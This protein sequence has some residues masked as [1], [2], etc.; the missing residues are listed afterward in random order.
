MIGYPTPQLRKRA[1]LV[2]VLGLALGMAG[3]SSASSGGGDSETG[4]ILWGEATEAAET[5]TDAAAE[6][7]PEAVAETATETAAEA[8]VDPTPFEYPCEPGAREACVTACVSAGQR[9]C[10]KEW[11]PCLPPGEF[12][13]N[14]TDDDCDGQVNEE[15]PLNPECQE[16]PV[17]ECPTAVIS[18]AEGTTVGVGT[19]LHLDG[20]ASTSPNGAVTA[21]AWGV[22]APVG[23]QAAFAPSASIVAPTFQ[24]DLAGQFLFTLEVTDDQGVKGCTPAQVAVTVKPVPP[25]DPEVGCADGQREGFVDLQAYTHIAGC[26]GAWDQPGVSPDSVQPTCG[27]QGGD[28]GQHAD[29]VGCSSVDLCATGWHLC[30]EWQEVAQKSPT[31]C[32]GATPANAPPKSLFFAMR[33]SSPNNSECTAWG[34]GF[35]DVFG[36]GNLGHALPA[37]KHCGPLDRV[38]AS[39]QPNSCGYNE[40]EPNLGPWQCLGGA[41]SHYHEGELVTKKGCANQS[42]SYDGLPL[43]PSDK[44]GVLCC[45]DSQ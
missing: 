44:G 18:V 30:K 15:C 21:W 22:S 3:C 14:C 12:C 25:V 35:N 8:E 42:C 26:S 29:G 34:T 2:V 19:T 23:S 38:L 36:C 11:G 37:D 43:G 40:A 27:R 17:K 1:W 9:Q 4:E 33:Q 32:A 7:A 24:V 41:D 13:G 39:T 5:A 16:P 31:G 20:G 28:D 45:R 10:L 6:P